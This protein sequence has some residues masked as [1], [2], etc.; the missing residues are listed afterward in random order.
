MMRQ[1]H[2]MASGI[3]TVLLVLGHTGGGAVKAAMAADPVPGQISMLYQHIQPSV[4][5]AGG[6]V[7][8]AIAHNATLQ[9]HVLRTS[10][11]VV[12]EALHAAQVRV[13]SGVYDLATGTVTLQ[14]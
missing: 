5:H 6:D 8:Q 4:A 14:G 7:G 9:A 13:A 1:T 3:T 2:T 12:R 11:T 10:S